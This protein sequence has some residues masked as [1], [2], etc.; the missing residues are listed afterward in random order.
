MNSTAIATHEVFAL[1]TAAVLARLRGSL[2]S[3]PVG[4]QAAD[5]GRTEHLRAGEL[6]LRLHPGLRASAADGNAFAVS[7]VV[8]QAGAD[9]DGYA[10]GDQV[11]GVARDHHS[12]GA[13]GFA[14]TSVAHV[15]RMPRSLSPEKAVTLVSSATMAWQM[16]FRLGRLEAGEI[17]AVITARSAVGAFALQLA[18]AHGVHAIA[19]TPSD[20]CSQLRELG[21]HR[22]EDMR[23]GALESACRVAAVVVDAVGG[24]IQRRALGAMQEGSVLLSCVSKP[25]LSRAPKGV[26]GELVTP[27]VTAR[28]LALVAALADAGHLAPTPEGWHW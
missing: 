2:D 8:V 22:V 28:D 21:A 5:V 19:V 26:R 15:A 24:F 10:A 20:C 14:V 13:D 27:A 4:S 3:R 17:L 16:L 25:D 11:F 6:L 1:S 12:R 23:A 7:G 9:A 18:R